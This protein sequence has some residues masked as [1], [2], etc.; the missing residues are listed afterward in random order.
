MRS[1]AALWRTT[2]QEE[3]GVQVWALDA[4]T[5]LIVTSFLTSTTTT[6]LRAAS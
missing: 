1:I 3:D 4:E 6:W 5:R 2:A